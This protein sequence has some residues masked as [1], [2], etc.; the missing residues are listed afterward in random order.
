MPRKANADHLK[1]VSLGPPRLEPPEALDAAE[2]RIWRSVVDAAPGGFLDSDAQLILRQVVCQIAVADRHAE[3]LRALAAQPEDRIEAELVLVEA[4]RKA[5]A[6]VITGMTTLR[7]TPRSRIRPRDAGR[8]LERLPAA[9][10]TR[11]WETRAPTLEAEPGDGD[12]TA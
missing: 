6:A 1:V 8:T 3:R 4:H 10:A 9:G 11:P 7:A 5:M 12:E 2:A